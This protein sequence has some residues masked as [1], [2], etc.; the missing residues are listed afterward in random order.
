MKIERREDTLRKE[1]GIKR[2]RVKGEGERI[3]DKDGYKDR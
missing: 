3:G 2:E 1:G